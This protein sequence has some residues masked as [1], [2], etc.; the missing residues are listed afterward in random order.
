MDGQIDEL[1]GNQR[2]DDV[3]IVVSELAQKEWL[4]GLEGDTVDAVEAKP[5]AE[6]H[7]AAISR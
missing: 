6:D 4:G 2:R 1:H 7:I 3:L 5:A